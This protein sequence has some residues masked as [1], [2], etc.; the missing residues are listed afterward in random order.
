MRVTAGAHVEAPVAAA[1]EPVEPVATAASTAMRAR[2]ILDA[3]A[4]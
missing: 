3:A 1:G 2:R 4:T